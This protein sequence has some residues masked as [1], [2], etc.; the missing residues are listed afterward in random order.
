MTFPSKQTRTVLTLAATLALAACGSP[1][2]PKEQVAI[3]NAAV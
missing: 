1:K 2:P 3:A